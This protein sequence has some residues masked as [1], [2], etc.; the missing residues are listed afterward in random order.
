VQKYFFSFALISF[1]ISCAPRY[2]YVPD[3]KRDVK[4]WVRDFNYQKSF[5]YEY[6]LKTS[7]SK[8]I[9]QGECIV[10]WA[11]HIKGLWDYGDTMIQ[12]EHIGINDQEW[13]IRDGKWEKSVRGEES[14]ILAQIKRV[15]EFDKF[16]FL[17]LDADN[18]F[19]YRLN[20]TLPY[21]A[22][23]RWREMIA[24]ISISKKNYLP[25]FIWV[26][27]PDSSVY[28]QV[29]LKNYNH[30]I[31]IKPQYFEMKDYQI[32][33]DS[34]VD[35]TKAI[36]QINRRL[37]LQNL[38]W[39]VWK[40]KEKIMLQAPDF[41]S[42]DDI[43]ELLAPG[44]TTLRGVARDSSEAVLIGFLINDPRKSIYLSDW[45]INTGMVKDVVIKFDNQFKPFML[46]KLKK[47]IEFPAHIAV[48]VDSDIVALLP[49]DKVK[50][51]DN[52]KIY[53]DMPYRDLF[54]IRSFICQPLFR[55]DILPVTRS[56]D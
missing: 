19:N 9:A 12:F 30:K 5:A 1:V 42:I 38:K 11:E 33:I 36:K 28:W 48:Q 53:L 43:K 32:I 44:I 51:M 41:Y 26:G 17:D 22:P 13:T 4:E 54:K 23:E 2:S 46:I 16:E 6:E 39:K 45:N 14:D 52:I 24:Y 18:D 15:L 29:K 40:T 55:I 20:A 37:N 50:K 49:L 3:P 25:S 47:K 21:L 7:R 10:N 8:I 27:L 56:S 35:R 31:A 34:T